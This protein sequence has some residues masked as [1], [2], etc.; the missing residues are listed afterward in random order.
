[1]MTEPIYK[2][3]LS[4]PT[5]AW[6]ELSKEEKREKLD[7]LNKLLIDVGGSRIIQCDATWASDEWPF[8]GVECFPSLKKAQ[9]YAKLIRG[10]GVDWLKYASVMSVLG[11][12][13]L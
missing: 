11:T 3:Y 7:Q 4:R 5:E 6:Y 10:E 1:M 12:E 9:E 13:D 2:L 8:W